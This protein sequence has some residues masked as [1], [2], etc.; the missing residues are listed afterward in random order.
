M[1]T[2]QTLAASEQLFYLASPYARYPGG[3][4]L[5]FR[6]VCSISADLLRAKVAHF[7]PIAQNHPVALYGHVDATDHSFWIPADIPLMKRCDALLIAEMTGWRESVGIAM[8]IEAFKD[9]RKPIWRL[10]PQT[11]VVVAHDE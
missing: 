7:C 4:N 9:M 3:M 6:Q 10:D 1:T 2:L 8:E 5:A 11:L